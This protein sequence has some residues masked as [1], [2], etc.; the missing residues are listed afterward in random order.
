M[1]IVICCIAKL[2]NL[3]LREFVTYH[4][5][6]G[7]SKVYVYDNNDIDGEFCRDVLEDDL[8]KERVVVREVRGLKYQQ[9]HV[10]NDFYQNE[11]FDWVAFIDVDE[12][13]SFTELSGF[14]NIEDFMRQNVES[15]GFDAVY[16]NWKCY[17]DDGNICYSP[18]DVR[19]RFKTPILP[20][21]FNINNVF[22][23]IPMNCHVK[24]IIKKGL[25]A[26]FVDNPHTPRGD[27][28]I[29]N[30][31]GEKV[32][33][34]PY[35]SGLNFEPCFIRHYVSKSMEEYVKKRLTKQ[36]ADQKGEHNKIDFFFWNLPTLSKIIAYNSYLR[37]VFGYDNSKLY[38]VKWSKEEK[39]RLVKYFLKWSYLRISY[40]LGFNRIKDSKVY[41][42][43]L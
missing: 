1:N 21:N 43:K 31:T 23:A 2:E 3:Y 35:S 4:L 10:Y 30:V 19:S 29:C 38:H 37:E 17:G 15:R 27:F 12:F 16:L 9:S 8:F 5:S 34:S 42:P 6:L 32:V 40:M 26:K 7:F 28:N 18:Q 24:T 22:K 41:E 20:L 39:I 36:L 33:N 13:V 25:E 14:S 11:D